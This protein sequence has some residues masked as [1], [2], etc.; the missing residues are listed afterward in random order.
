MKTRSWLLVA[1]ISISLTAACSTVRLPQI[2]AT[3]EP[4]GV[5][6]R[7][8]K[9]Y[10][11]SQ[12]VIAALEA[13]RLDRGAYPEKLTDLTPEYLASAPTATDELDFSYSSTG[14]SYSFSFH[15]RGPG[16]NTCTYKP[17]GEWH[18]SGAF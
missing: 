1:F 7:A 12:P 3:D 10:A 8:E 15:Y 13:Y 2:V 17:E 11:F 14:D 5:G 9:G 16:M 4:P 6:E 18:C